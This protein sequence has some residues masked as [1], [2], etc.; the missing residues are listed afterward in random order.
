MLKKMRKA[1]MTKFYKNLNEIYVTG[2]FEQVHQKDNA[3]ISFSLLFI[4]FKY[5]L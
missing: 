5:V 3:I 1:K 4:S 2:Y